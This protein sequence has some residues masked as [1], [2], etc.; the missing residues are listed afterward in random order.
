MGHPQDAAAA[1]RDDPGRRR[2]G[3]ARRP[4]QAAAGRLPRR[5]GSP[6]CAWRR[7]RSPATARTS[8][9]TLRPA[10]GTVPLAVADDGPDRCGCTA[11][12]SAAAAPTTGGRGPVAAHRP[13]LPHD[14]VGRA[15]RRGRRPRAGPQPGRRRLATHR[16]GRRRRRRCT[17]WTAGQL[18]AFLGWAAEHV[19][20]PAV[21][22]ARGSPAC[23]AARPWRC[24]GVTS[25]LDAG[26]RQRPPV[27]RLVRNAARAPVIVE[28]D[29]KSGKP[30]LVDL[31]AATVAV[32][33]AHR[34][35]A[36]RRGAPAR[37]R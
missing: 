13:L 18:A 15:R 25:D 12:S 21:A 19:A 30:R 14:P 36:R 37:P 22:C 9:C 27:R 11:S 17:C 20:S 2:A 28:G 23:A 16:A 8:G 7:R 6:G 10:L 29:T 3:R 26:D 4:E 33:R 24:A 5:V 34:K 1:L 35:R 31:D 32:L